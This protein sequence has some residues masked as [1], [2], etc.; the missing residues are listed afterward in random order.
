MSL[1][2]TAAPGARRAVPGVVAWKVDGHPGKRPV[3]VAIGARATN[4]LAATG[5]GELWF[6]D[7]R[8]RLGDSGVGESG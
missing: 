2:T 8:Q 6:P 5:R 7:P 1:S 3:G 4:T